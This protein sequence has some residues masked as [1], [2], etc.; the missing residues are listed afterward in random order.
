MAIGAIGGSFDVTLSGSAS[1]SIPIKVAPGTSG[2]EPKLQLIYDSQSIG[3][4]LGAGWSI[5]GF[6]TI[7][8]G[9]KDQFTDNVIEGVNL[10]DS[11]ALYFDGQR[12]IP[13]DT[14]ASGAAQKI[15]YRK[16]LD[17]QTRITQIGAN[18]RTSIFRVQT[19][20]GLTL[21]FDGSNNSHILLD[22]GN[23]LAFAESRAI[24]SAGNYIDFY[25]DIN[26]L[27]DGNLVQIRYTGHVDLDHDGNLVTGRDQ[28]PFATVDFSYENAP[29]EIESFVA[30]RQ[31]LRSKRLKS[32]V[33]KVF[34]DRIGSGTGTAHI[35]SRYEF[36]YED[37]ETANRFVLK[38]VHQFGEGENSPELCPTAFNY[39]AQKVGWKIG[40]AFPVAAVLA[41]VENLSGAYRFGHFTKTG[42]LPDLLFAVQLE[43][44]LETFAFRNDGTNFVSEEKYKSPIPFVTPQGADLGVI[45]EDI[46]GDGRVDLLQSYQNGTQAEQK[47]AYFAADDKFDPAGD[48]WR[49]PFLVAH[50]G[51]VVA[52][53]RFAK[54]SGGPGPD[55]LYQSG[56]Q[57]GFLRNT[58]SGWVPEAGLALPVEMDARA[59]LIDID[60]SGKLSLLGASKNAGGRF[61]WHVF[62]FQPAGWFSGPSWIEENGP[63]FK[64][65]FSADTDPEAIR[66]IKFSSG[67]GGCPGLIVATD[68]AGSLH[69]AYEASSTGWKII[70]GK[71]PPF[72]LVDA[73]GVASRAMV[74]DINGDGLSDI[75]AN[76]ETSA[77]NFSR[78]AYLQTVSG[79]EKQ[80]D[81][82]KFIPPLLDTNVA[83]APKIGAY[84]GDING[85][86]SVDIVLPSHTRTAGAFGNIFLGK[87]SGFEPTPNYAPPIAFSK[88]DRKDGGVRLIDLHGTGLPDVI[89]SRETLKDGRLETTAGAYTNSGNGWSPNV[90]KLA[91][92]VAFAGDEIAGNPAQ[93]FD[94]DGDGYTDL[95]YA[96][97]RK[98]GQLSAKL[99]LNRS[100]PDVAGERAWEEAA[101]PD[102]LTLAPP[103][104]DPTTNAELPLS[105]YRVG[106]MGV[107]FVKLN[108]ER[109]GMLVSFLPPKGDAGGVPVPATVCEGEGED[110]T[111]KLDRDKLRRAAFVFNAATKKW[112]PAPQY[113]PPVPFVAQIDSSGESSRDLFVQ[114]IDVNADGLP[115]I[116]ARFAHPHDPAV[117][118]HEVWLNTGD[119][120][121][122]DNSFQAPMALDESIRDPKALIQWADVNGDGHADIVFTKRD[123]ATNMSKTW[124]GTGRGWVERGNWKVPLE[125]ISDVA[126]DPSFR[127]VDVDGDGYLDVIYARK[128]AD[129]AIEKGLFINNGSTWVKQDSSLVPDRPFIDKDGADQGVRLLS[130]TGRGLTDVVQSLRGSSPTVELNTASRADV[131]QKITDG[132]SLSTNVYYQTL[133][134]ADA[135]NS[136]DPSP[137]TNLWS[138]VYERGPPRPYPIVA[139]IPTSY[140]VR[141]AVVDEGGGRSVAFSYRYGEYRVDSLA[142]KSLGFG[143]RETFNEV[144]K[145]L[146]RV[147]LEQNAKLRNSPLR[148]ATC[149]LSIERKP[150]TSAL[151]DNLCPRGP[152]RWSNWGQKVSETQNKWM[153]TE[154]T[155]G[156]GS[157]PVHMIR[158]INLELTKSV[159]FELDGHVVTATTDIFEYDQPA[160]I[161]DR[162]SNA[163]KVRNEVG[164]GTYIETVN[165]YKDNVG[166][167][168]LGRLT[169]SVVTKV[170]DTISPASPERYTEVRKASF[171]YDSSTGL[172][173]KQT[174]N[175]GHAR[176]VTTTYQRDTYGNVVATTVSAAG[177][178]AR[179]DTVKYDRL[180]RFIVAEK[181]ALGHRIEKEVSQAN[182]LPRAVIDANGLKTQFEY[183][184]FG[185]LRR[186]ISATGVVSSIELLRPDDL[187]DSRGLDGIRAAYISQK[188]IATLP[189]TLA[190][191]DIKGRVVR[192][193]TDGYTRDS[194]AKRPVYVD[195]TYDLLGRVEKT[196]LPYE[197]GAP[198]YWASKHYDALGRVDSSVYPDGLVTET[199]YAG[200]PEGGAKVTVTVD[201]EG[202]K[203]RKSSSRINARKQVVEVIDALNGSLRYSYDAG[204]RVIK[205]VGP[206]GAVTTHKYDELGNRVETSDPDLGVWSYSYDPF[207]RVLE[208]KDAKNQVSKLEYDVLGRPTKREHMDVETKWTYDESRHGL[209]KLSE[210]ENSN[211]YRRTYSYDEFGR[212]DHVA[213]FI[214]GGKFT[215]DFE[216]DR[217][218]RIE[219]LLYPT[220]FLVRNVYDPKGFLVAVKNSTTD[221]TFWAAKKID[222]YGR[223]VE[224]SLG[225]GVTTTKKFDTKTGKTKKITSRQA[226]GSTILDLNLEY[227]QIGNLT[228]RIETTTSK[229]E[230]FTKYDAL[231][232]LREVTLNGDR[233]TFDYDAAGRFTYK[234]DVGRYKYLEGSV[235]TDSGCARP[236]HAVAQTSRSD[237]IEKYKYDCNGNMIAAPKVAY[238]YTAD[239]H[240]A[241]I[242]TDQEHFTEFEYGPDGEKFRQ[243]ER[244]GKEFFETLYLGAYER[245][246]DRSKP[247]A[248]GGPET[249]LRHRYYLMNGDGVFAAYDTDVQYASSF[250]AKANSRRTQHLAGSKV[251]KEIWYLHKDQLGSILR[252]TDDKGKVTQKFWYDPWG[253]IA[254]NVSGPDEAWTKGFAGHDAIPE[255]ALIHMNARVYS[256]RLGIFLSVDSI[257]Q[258]PLDTQTGNGYAYVRNNPLKFIDPSGN[259]FFD[260]IAAPFRALGEAIGAVVG[261]IV[262][263]VVEAGKWLS[264][265][266]RTVVIVAAVVIVTGGM[267]AGLAGAIW[268]GMAA[269]ATAGALGAALYGGS[270]EDIIAG[271]VKGAVIGAFTGAA[272]Y[273]VGYA[274][275]GSAGSIGSSNSIGAFAGHGVVGGLSE[276]A[277]SGNFWRGFIASA[278]GHA[279]NV[280][281]VDHRITAVNVAQAAIVGGTMAQI[282]GGKF[283]NGAILGAFT[284]QFAAS[285][286]A[287]RQGRPL[288]PEEREVFG[289]SFTLDVLDNARVHE[290]ETPW[291]LKADARAVTIGD[292][293]YMR[294]GEYSRYSAEGAE[295]LGHELTHVEQFRNGMTIPAYI[296]NPSKYEAPAYDRQPEFSADFCRRYSGP[297]CSPNSGLPPAG[298][299]P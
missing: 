249:I 228:K 29:R 256:P 31:I 116:A 236:F 80:R 198:V 184:T 281:G 222:G 150:H 242:V 191:F 141:R 258:M 42:Q 106:D 175:V 68:G 142:M 53:Y 19:K 279:V 209:G 121:T 90:S 67:A 15:V 45:V 227:D 97:K 115:D 225:N 107:R 168:Y 185:R 176:A 167:W 23:V 181:N 84:F 255:Y 268:T 154:G 71:A 156:G 54:L 278:A 247:F 157:L 294:P 289:D 183:D 169:E 172:L 202:P 295:L 147:E 2:T 174:A 180:K 165:Q 130:V 211:K 47:G 61:E 246:A 196:S 251:L 14:S 219:K 1:Y 46:N 253:A 239:N 70:S 131:L 203:Q 140:V 132:Y 143:W 7:T 78:F 280:Y 159:T 214:D 155:V 36:E 44:R 274:F 51:K 285:L 286:A 82:S 223:T 35:A 13:V 129:G 215:T 245:L 105:A 161:L 205:M 152:P 259:G 62:R 41:D 271:A 212:P 18:L 108:K 187:G 233:Q 20:G 177:E 118:V 171:D 296:V 114:V 38:R 139:P 110:K 92:P 9:P 134:E 263:L 166:K 88:T 124:L 3:G 77:G 57:R 151:P 50:D 66:E 179:T 210:V 244:Q 138:R 100:N 76:R 208:Q 123:A 153:I 192:T 218:N 75:I 290:N 37:R 6:S 190:F 95:Y 16:L 241:R 98:D 81:D 93:F 149:V 158:Q 113:L 49:L 284:Y 65:Q 260:V 12:L 221:E 145:T 298:R 86:H 26:R 30:G 79:W 288:S 39:A 58:G 32:I 55:L 56:E 277:Q 234:E 220:G 144:A 238:E 226:G 231:D 199:L 265:N 264:E 276:S 287:K 254:K 182:G 269:G 240:L 64:P 111:C 232:R 89:F 237:K 8:R 25:Y 102:A 195:T 60:C 33:S 24:D 17:D 34:D 5:S 217:L 136:G 133:L 283:A 178:Q 162:H 94:I 101:S 164:D 128:K 125:S 126:G 85:D 103:I 224:E 299:S 69:A 200:L 204:G 119:G 122:L 229:N 261:G 293:I 206:A 74:G 11:D 250:Y 52:E 297:G 10:N 216:Y 243:Y 160:N 87:G 282:S 252:I 230:K 63:Q 112:I 267:G 201:P 21:I 135:S 117:K 137:V 235:D 28:K 186:E 275:S 173:S 4:P 248:E 43:G 148:E 257:N 73:S 193:I 163:L 27:G 292:H 189:A 91:P 109:L 83:N 270:I 22:N 170:G 40:P 120:W 213:V 59:R 272:T 48:G 194:T 197:P 146:T 207:G 273:G 72:S 291:W 188:Q 99:Y 262:H 96:Y 104:K 127:L 266:W